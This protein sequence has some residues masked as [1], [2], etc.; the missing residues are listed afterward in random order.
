MV[1]AGSI[2]FKCRPHVFE[3]IAAIQQ[4]ESYGVSTNY[5]YF[6]QNRFQPG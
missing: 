2:R 4:R 6:R 3:M 5:C 1:T